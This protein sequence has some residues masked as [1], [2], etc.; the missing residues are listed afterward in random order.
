MVTAAIA[1][2]TFFI[3]AA[4]KPDGTRHCL[5]EVLNMVV[6]LPFLLAFQRGA[7]TACAMLQPACRRAAPDLMAQDQSILLNAPPPRGAVTIRS[8]ILNGQV[9]EN[10]HYR[11]GEDL[12]ASRV[13][14][15]RYSRENPHVLDS[16]GYR[17]RRQSW[18][19]YCIRS[20]RASRRPRS[21]CPRR[22]R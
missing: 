22:S 9:F 19:G 12:G 4:Q 2:K 16:F 10:L 18:P 8:Q 17:R 7:R 11:A 13:R 20:P 15:T 6:L 21:P 14:G 1:A 3:L 5:G